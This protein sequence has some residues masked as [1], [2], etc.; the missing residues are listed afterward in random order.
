MAKRPTPRPRELEE[1]IMMDRESER[2]SRRDEGPSRLQMEQG[3]LAPARSMRPQP[4]PK[5][6]FA[7]GGEIRGC[8]DSQMSGKGFRGNY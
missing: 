4:R 6:R 1:R 8:S 2:I 3:E 7:E 5:K